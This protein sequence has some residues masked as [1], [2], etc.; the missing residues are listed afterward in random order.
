MEQEEDDPDDPEDQTSDPERGR[1]SH[2]K[3]ITPL[4]TVG[5]D[6]NSN[7]GHEGERTQSEKDGCCDSFRHP[8]W[9]YH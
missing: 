7:I 9:W 8:H 2:I 1:K 6:N 3:E 5:D 4:I